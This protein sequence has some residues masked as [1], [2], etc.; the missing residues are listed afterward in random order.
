LLV[1]LGY[2]EQLELAYRAQRAL[3][4]QG[5]QRVLVLR[6]LLALELKVL[7]VQLE[8][9]ALVRLVKWGQLGRQV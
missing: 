3:R 4:E 9:R 7:L 5:A 6:E 8:Q 1:Q 2:K